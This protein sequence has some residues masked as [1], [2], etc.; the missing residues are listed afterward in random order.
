[1]LDG[2]I[3]VGGP[4]T[5]PTSI[6]ATLTFDDATQMRVETSCNQ[7]SAT[8]TL[9]EGGTISFGPV[10]LTKM[11]CSEDRNKLE[12]RIVNLLGLPSYWSAHDGTL[13]LYPANVTDTGMLFHAG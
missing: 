5:V 13:S 11:A 6:E 8:V 7:G 2:F 4:D 10:T 3:T 9:G 12:A 1:M